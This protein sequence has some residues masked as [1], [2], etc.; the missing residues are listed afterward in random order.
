MRR[1]SLFPAAFIA[2]FCTQNLT[3]A[4]GTAVRVWQDSIHLP[5]Y[6]EGDADPNPQFAAYGGDTV[7]YP[8]AVRMN[9]T[10]DR[11]DRVWRTL[12]LDN[13][14]L[15]CRVLPDLGGHL[16]SCRDKRNGREMF[17]ANPVI[18]TAAIGLRGAWA[19]LGIQS[20]FPA[21]HTRTTVSPVDFAIRSESD[22][23][24]RVL[25]EEIDRITGMQWRVEFV[26]RPGS[27]VLE[28]RVTL[29]NRS[30]TRWPYY[31]WASA[32]VPLDDPAMKFIMPSRLVASHSIE[33]ID[34][35]P[36]N[37]AGKDE[38]QLKN[39]KESGAW[40][41]YRCREPFL[42]VYNPGSRAGV[43][44]FADPNIVQGKKVWF[45]GSESDA[46]Y[47][48]RELTD[49]FSSYIEIQG[50][51]FENQET[52]EF[53][54]PEQSRTFSDYWI[55]I[56]DLG[57][58]SRVTADAVMNLERRSDRTTGPVLALELSVTRAV[59]DGV[60]RVMSDGRT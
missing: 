33:N 53:L 11:Q 42:A 60:I 7:N 50:G 8:Y 29:Y 59:K 40:F 18:K 17:Y 52:F 45:W 20:N 16:Y 35:W 9:F 6:R 54:E 43:A 51:L 58:V 15:A 19:A 25:V 31:W 21:G 3:P 44:H 37:S 22:G 38:S 46:N 5:T 39:H 34:S 23:S 4:E 14:Y 57:G 36:I 41:A 32:A 2:F 47:V 1:T 49:N 26:L 48:R 24:G 28:Q 30:H 55:P 27:T 12:N 13:E 56:H 10:K